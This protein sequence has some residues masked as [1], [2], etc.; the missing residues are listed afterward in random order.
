M[1]G[2][3]TAILDLT[4]NQDRF[5]IKIDGVPYL[6]KTPSD[7]TLTDYK[8]LEQLAPQTAALLL[9]K[10][11]NSKQTTELSRLLDVA[12]RLALAA[13]SDVLDRL[14]DLNRLNIFKVFTELSLPSL[15]RTRASLAGRRLGGTKPSRG[16]RGSTGATRRRGSR[17][18]RSAPFART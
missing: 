9:K 4:T 13:P 1:A 15:L 3:P 17:S 7:L 18:S 16:S 14:G 10:T 8:T 12:C 5:N 11:L 6:I 2:S